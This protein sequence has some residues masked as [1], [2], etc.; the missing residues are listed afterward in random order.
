[1]SVVPADGQGMGSARAEHGGLTGSILAAALAAAVLLPG[2]SSPDRLEANEG[3]VV[4]VV[5]RDFSIR[6]STHRVRSGPMVLRVVNKGPVAHELIVVRSAD[7]PLPLRADDVTI[8]EDE[9]EDITVGVLEP[10]EPGTS[11]D[12]PLDL[13][14]GMYSVVCNMSGHFMGG[15]YDDL[16]VTA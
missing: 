13:E 6:L 3:A 14:P 1:M 7:G 4:R 12:L 16:E 8:D 9:I 2:C 11:R 5:E 15:M 10:G